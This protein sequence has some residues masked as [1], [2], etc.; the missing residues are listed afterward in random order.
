MQTNHKNLLKRMPETKY[1]KK[2]N[3]SYYLITKSVRNFHYFLTRLQIEST[4]F[5]IVIREGRMNKIE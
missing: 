4:G 1:K 2:N 5:C 3:T